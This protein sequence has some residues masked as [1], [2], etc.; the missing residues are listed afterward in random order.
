MRS[1]AILDCNIHNQINVAHVTL[2]KAAPS[3][4][5]IFAVHCYKLSFGSFGISWNVFGTFEMFWIHFLFLFGIFWI[6]L[7]SFEFFWDNLDLF[8][9]S[10][11]FLESFKFFGI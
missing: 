8:G 10:W 1:I 7:E 2:P 5:K 3:T 9:I 11:I 6:F 4:V